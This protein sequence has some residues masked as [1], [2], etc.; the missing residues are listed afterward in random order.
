[1]MGMKTSQFPLILA[2]GSPRR[3]ELLAQ[4]GYRFEVVPP[5]L[6]EPRIVPGPHVWPTGCAEALAY[7]KAASVARRYPD[8]LV[9]GADTVVVHG[10]TMVGKPADLADARRILTC[11]FDGPNEVITG[12]AI[13]HL[14]R[15]HRI[16]THDSTTL[17]MRAMTERELEDY[18]ASGAW[19]DK[20][21]AY[22]LQEGG[23]KFVRQMV[24]SETNV[25]GLPM[26][27]L[28]EVLRQFEND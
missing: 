13:L 11:L 4:A 7:F 26:E 28:A 3:R 1:M 18:L 23:D 10:Q 19:Q 15:H 21:G 27:K 14:N 8:R 25:V 24:G 17:D 20:A 9:I 5:T 16:I 6:S 2:S 12:L 22:A